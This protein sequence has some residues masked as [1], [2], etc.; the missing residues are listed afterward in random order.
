VNIWYL[1]HYAGGPGL[2]PFDRAYELGKAWRD[3]E[4]DQTV[5]LARYHH[6]LQPNV[7]V[8][9][10]FEI[11]GVRFRSVET[12]AYQGNSFGRILNMWD[13]VTRFAKSTE[14]LAKPDL[15][16]ASSPHPFT[17]FPAYW[18]ARKYNAK[19]VFEVRDIWPLSITEI[20]NVSPLHPFVL[21]CALTEQFA[22]R[23]ADAIASVL[24]R[25]S[26]YLRKKGFASK[27]SVWV[28]NGIPRNSVTET[29]NVFGNQARIAAE[30]MDN[31]RKSDM[32][33]LIYAGSV[34]PPNG[35]ELLIDGLECGAKGN[36]RKVGAIIVGAGES[37]HKIRERSDEAGL[38]H[39]HFTGKVPKNDAV[40]LLSYADMAYAG[41]RDFGSVF[42]Y[43]VSPNKIAEYAKAGLP[44]I[45]PIAPCGDPVSESGGGIT[46]RAENGAD[47]WRMIEEMIE[48]APD[49]RNQLGNYLRSYMEREYDYRLVAERY[50]ALLR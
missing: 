33:V 28:P 37:L 16:I 30:K 3:A 21:L 40:K 48:L 4:H 22:L 2:G 39:V 14:G 36:G 26:N 42:Q 18:A 43:G 38:E 46:R 44:V 41:L 19:L 47:V 25:M 6:L 13:F 24:P 5:F 49:R 35:I 34:G 32:P 50:T 29:S 23:K 7:D 27:P 11:G 8:Q 12:R 17:I 45:L 10:E 1:H 9:P 31:W 15:I 20:L